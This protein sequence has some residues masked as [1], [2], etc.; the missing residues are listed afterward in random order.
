MHEVSTRAVSG[1]C[2]TDEVESARGTSALRVRAM[3]HAPL[4]RAGAPMRARDH[5]RRLKR[6]P[7]ART[8]AS[9]QLSQMH[10]RQLIAVRLTVPGGRG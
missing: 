1:N 6:A 7:R 4:E 3:G 2:G 9:D 8:A 10:L 5:K